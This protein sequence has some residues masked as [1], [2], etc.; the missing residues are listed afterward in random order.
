VEKLRQSNPNPLVR[1]VHAT[2]L[3][4]ETR[5]AML[6]SAMLTLANVCPVGIRA[7]YSLGM[8]GGAEYRRA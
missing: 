3:G 2:A 5:Y 1:N 6:Q 8:N 4:R 7:G